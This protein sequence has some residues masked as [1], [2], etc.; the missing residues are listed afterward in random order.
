MAEAQATRQTSSS[1]GHSAAQPVKRRAACDECRTKKL[2]CSGASVER[3]RC[4]RCERENIAC[5]FSAQKQ[6]GRPKKRHG[7]NAENNAITK[8]RNRERTLEIN[9]AQSIPE[10]DIY[11][12][13]FTPGGSLQPWLR[14][15]WPADVSGEGGHNGHGSDGGLPGLTPDAGMESSRSSSLENG[16]N[17]LVGVQDESTSLLLDPSLTGI[18]DAPTSVQASSTPSCACLSTLYLTLNNLQVMD[19]DRCSFPFSLHPLREAMQTASE[20]LKCEACPSRFISA[21]QNTQLVG[22][23]LMSIVER[24][25]KVL[26]HINAEAVRAQAAGE[27]KKFTLAD[28]NS[29]TLH[30]HTGGL[31]CSAAFSIDLS[32]GEWKSMCKKVVRAEVHGPGAGNNCCPYFVG[33]CAQMEQRQAR[34]HSRPLPKDFPRDGKGLA[35]GMERESIN[36]GHANGEYL[37]L[38]LVGF[39]RRLVATLDWS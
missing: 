7:E 21:I 8:R 15:G 4:T 23:L 27:S 12:S 29:S 6:M 24:F 17:S 35:V 5:V 13:A 11:E 36:P 19:N 22:T 14:D 39:A 2:K 37:C 10:M 3:P 31:N 16:Q 34:W 9:T 32:P 26:G 30:L 38:K 1:P 18:A 28:L 25:G 20:V 33:L